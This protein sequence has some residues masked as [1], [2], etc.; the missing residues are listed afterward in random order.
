M[1]LLA[2]PNL[3]AEQS[4]TAPNVLFIVVDDMND[5]TSYLK[6]HPQ[7]RTPNLDRFAKESVRFTQAYCNAPSCNPFPSICNAR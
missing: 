5:W 6:G 4:R 3:D 7:A 2:A 1:L